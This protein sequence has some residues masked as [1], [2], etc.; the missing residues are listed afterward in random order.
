MIKKGSSVPTLAIRFVAVATGIFIAALI[1]RN[2]VVLIGNDARSPLGLSERIWP[3][4]GT[5]ELID[6]QLIV[7]QVDWNKHSVE[8]VAQAARRARSLDPLDEWPF[9]LA[10]M[11]DFKSED[12]PSATQT[13]QQARRRNARAPTPH[14]LL[15]LSYAHRGMIDETLSE[16]VT[17][18]N[19]RP[20]LSE[21]LMPSLIAAVMQENSDKVL[22]KI[23]R[24]PQVLVRLIESASQTEGAESYLPKLFERPGVTR[25]M[26]V[27]SIQ[28]L[29]LRGRHDLA[30]SMWR[31]LA[32]KNATIPYDQDFQGLMGPQPYVW[33]ITTD[34]DVTADF[35]KRNAEGEIAL[36]VEAFGS[37][38]SQVVTQ[39][40][41]IP[42]GQHALRIV[43]N[44]V[45][46]QAETGRMRWMLSCAGS[47]KPLVQTEF[48]MIEGVQRRDIRFTIPPR[49]CA[50][51]TL[52]LVALPGEIRAGHRMRF[53]KIRLDGKPE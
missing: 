10:G 53:E 26:K 43:G 40:I 20:Q 38:M 24:Y 5:L 45:D 21:S 11:I 52:S 4:D 37:T 25:N 36:D 18:I 44:A 32:G 3:A 14:L 48:T 28:T 49:D 51:Q 47:V 35:S 41:K 50:F 31:A 13:L 46:P 33:T 6:R 12:F 23:D 29:A 39:T 30:Y 42:G 8:E 2:A 16:L 15:L 9:A 19:L 17:F 34:G 1:L 22:A 7:Q 27:D